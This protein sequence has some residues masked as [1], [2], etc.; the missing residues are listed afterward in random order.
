M[1]NF[2][3][4]IF[5]W[6]SDDRPPKVIKGKTPKWDKNSVN[7]QS[8]MFGTY[9]Q[10]IATPYK[11]AE[12]YA[13]YESMDEM[14]DVSTVLD[15]YAEDCT[16]FDET[17]GS[18]IWIETKNEKVQKSLTELFQRIKITE[19][20]EPITRDLGKY[21]DDFAE[22][23]Q[24]DGKIIS[25][26]F[27]DPAKIERIE[28]EN[29]ILVGFEDIA[30]LQELETKAK[31]NGGVIENPKYTYKPWDIIHFRLYRRK[32]EKDYNKKYIYGTSLLR[33][34]ERTARQVRILDDLLMVQRLTNSFDRRT[35]MIDTG[36]QNVEE[37]MFTIKMWKKGLKRTA[38]KDPTAG[39]YDSLFATWGWS[40]DLFFPMPE[41]SNSRVETLAGT[42]NV[43]DIVD[44]EHFRDK[45]Y[46]SLRAPKEFFGFEGRGAFD[47]KSSLSQQSQKWGRACGSLQRAVINGIYYICQIQLALDGIDP[48]TDFT[49]GMVTPSDLE[50]LSR[51]EATQTRLDIADRYANLG[52]TLGAN[53]TE[54]NKMVAIEIMKFS[55]AQYEILFAQTTEE[56]VKLDPQKL[57][58]KIKEL[59][60]NKIDESNSFVTKAHPDELPN[61][62]ENRDNA[63]NESAS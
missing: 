3:G 46:G 26:D 42:G 23:I 58:E 27:K 25:L 16:Q 51:L 8:D 41:G 34:S 17:H 24:K 11:R 56:S 54:W 21:G 43:S 32:R 30:K 62:K 52:E 35:F 33:G 15:A 44:I 48:D 57:S 45:F 59:I 5:N 55:E 29:G 63:V 37:E 2:L 61:W 10:L 40:E 28:N 12:K 13:V 20:H 39:S 1:S 47:S 19:L 9:Q 50:D 22:L 38:H 60:A 4:K 7:S 31:N 49:I 53:I 6:S 14:P 36:R 18:S